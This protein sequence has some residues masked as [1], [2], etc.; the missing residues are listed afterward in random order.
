MTIFCSHCHRPLQA[1]MSC[2]P[3]RAK[4]AP[5]ASRPFSDR[6]GMQSLSLPGHVSQMAGWL[7]R[8]T[9]SASKARRDQINAELQ[10]LR[11]LLPISA[12]E[13]ERLSYLHTMALVCLRLRGAQLFPPGL[14]PPAGP[15]LGTELLSLLPGFLL[16][17]SADNKLVYIS[18]NVAQV[19]GLSVVELL[20]QGDTVFDILD[21]RVGEDVHKKLLLAQEEP[22]R[23][24]T[25]VSEMRTSKA[26]RLQHGGNRV[27][28]V[29]GRFVA[30]RWPPSPSTTAFL[31]LC[32]PVVQS[33][34]DGE[35]ASQD[36]IFQSM[37]LLDMTFI[38]VTESVTYHLGYH[39][40]ELVGQSW[41]SLL[42]P[43]DA[44]LAAAQ[45]RAVALGAG[46]GPAA[47]TAVVRVLRKDRAW[48]WLRVWARRDG[49]CIT[50]TCR[51]LR[52]EEAAHLRARQP[53]A[54]APPAGRDLGRL[55]EQLR[56]LA[57]SLSPPAPRRWPRPEETEDDA[58]VCLGNS[59][60]DPPQ[61]LR[62]PFEQKI[63]CNI[64]SVLSQVS[65][66]Q[67]C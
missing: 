23:E 5:S 45:H 33:P 44:D 8:S 55:A 9:K 25:F 35:A 49:G 46:A 62:F 40:E 56:A 37:H 7:C 67:R 28:A 58:S 57:D 2:L 16:V 48:T 17:L 13:K 24:V 14:A 10:A 34:T 63:G 21:G 66:L 15:A 47:G 26:F 59:L 32:T 18:E 53:R 43:E 38:D 51:C 31:A 27:V 61:F 4:Q 60:L 65:S 19:L 52:E 42:H 20:A 30:L 41:Y 11:S 6:Q 12:E 3:R 50:C 64:P 39:R 1:E 36:D 54:A 22:G 29:C